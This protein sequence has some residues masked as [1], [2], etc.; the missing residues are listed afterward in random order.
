MNP[1]ES[2]LDTSSA[3]D[4]LNISSRTLET[5]RLTGGGPAFVKV[6]RRVRYHRSDL[7]SWLADRRR[8]STSD[9]GHVG[10][11]FKPNV[12][13]EATAVT[14]SKAP[15]RSQAEHRPD[16]ALRYARMGLRVFP[17]QPGAKVPACKWKEEATSDADIIRRWFDGNRDYNFAVVVPDGFVV[18]DIDSA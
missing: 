6:G 9:P 8:T 11:T 18:L 2:L 16:H 3:A 5:W 13:V 4:F 1:T 15:A 10:V 17:C 7:E 14:T 12:T